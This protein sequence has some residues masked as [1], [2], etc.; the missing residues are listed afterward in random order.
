MPP[1]ARFGYPNDFSLLFGDERKTYADGLVLAAS[2]SMV[3]FLLWML[4]ASILACLGKDRVG[5]WSGAPFQEDAHDAVHI[6]TLELQAGDDESTQNSG[7]EEIRLSENHTGTQSQLDASAASMTTRGASHNCRGWSP[8]D[9]IQAVRCIFLTSGV[10]FLVALMVIATSGLPTAQSAV[11]SFYQSSMDVRMLLQEARQIVT[12]EMVDIRT[13]AKSV[14]GRL[15]QEL[16]RIQEGAEALEQI[17]VLIDLTTFDTNAVDAVLRAIQWMAGHIE[18]TTKYLD[19]HTWKTIVV[20]QVFAVFPAC[21]MVSAVANATGTSWRRQDFL[22]RWVVLPFFM[23]L[24]FIA[25]CV[26]TVMVIASTAS[27][28]ACLPGGLSNTPDFTILDSIRQAGLDG[29][30]YQFVYHY[31]SFCTVGEH[32][33]DFLNDFLPNIVRHWWT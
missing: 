31:V 21:L 29:A 5:F 24:V 3:A 25:I 1:T 22:I 20:L 7:M 26:T 16:G 32:P 2:L 10:V 12:N 6:K 19:F 15:Q 23:L 11:D 28:D 33:T 18:R 14:R 30:V 9:R 13:L 4:I 17:D 27:R 8:Q